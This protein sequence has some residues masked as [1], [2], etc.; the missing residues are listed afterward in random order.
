MLMTTATGTVTAGLQLSGISQSI[1]LR[2]NRF[3]ELGLGFR[4]ARHVSCGVI[5]CVI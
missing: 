2:S 5:V 1:W 4:F 3:T